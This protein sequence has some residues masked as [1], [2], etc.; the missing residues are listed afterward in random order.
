M[1][2]SFVSK[3][4]LPGTDELGH[5]IKSGLDALAPS[6]RSRYFPT[7]FSTNLSSTFSFEYKFPWIMAT[8]RVE[9][10]ELSFANDNPYRKEAEKRIIAPPS[11]YAEVLRFTHKGSSRR[12]LTLNKERQY[13]MMSD[14]T[15]LAVTIRK[16][17]PY[18]PVNEDIRATGR[19]EYCEYPKIPQ[20][21]DRNPI[22]D[23]RY[24][25]IAHAEGNTSIFHRGWFF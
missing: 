2:T 1:E 17:T 14:R 11:T 24:S 15:V 12:P 18:T 21:T 19:T 8:L 4:I 13:R 9:I 25:R 23:R 5:A 10:R 6:V 3:G 7:T 22:W 16:D 20:G